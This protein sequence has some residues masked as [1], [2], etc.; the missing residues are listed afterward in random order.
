MPRIE[1]QFD[2][3]LKSLSRTAGGR[4]SESAPELEQFAPVLSLLSALPRR[5]VPE[6]SLRRRYLHDVPAKAGRFAWLSFLHL[7]RAAFVSSL[8]TSLLLA[9]GGTAFG[10]YR[11]IP[12][13]KLYSVKKAAEHV[14]LSFASAQPK[15]L[16]SR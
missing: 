7:S 1:D 8:V 2:G 14:Q 13:E 16:C 5:A 9:T 15:R 12:G 10:A 6:A 11:S 3:Y 4:L